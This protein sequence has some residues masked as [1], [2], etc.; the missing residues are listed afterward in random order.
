MSDL[1]S[2]VLT[3]PVQ[4]SAM[5]LIQQVAWLWE[6][7]DDMTAVRQ[8]AQV[9]VLRALAA[10]SSGSLAVVSKDEAGVF[11]VCVE[12]K[13]AILLAFRCLDS[14]VHALGFDKIPLLAVDT[15]RWTTHHIRVV[16]GS[17]IRH[18]VYLGP[19]C[20]IMPSFIN[21]GASIG[22]CTMIDSGATVGCAFIGERCH[23]SSNVTIGGVLEPMQAMPVIIEDDV[24]IGA[25]CHVVEGVRIGRGS[26]LATGVVLTSG[27][28]IIDRSTGHTLWGNIPP[29]SLVVPGAYASGR[30]GLSIQCAVIVKT[31]EPGQSPKTALNDWLR[32]SDSLP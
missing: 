7:R 16:P 8:E 4:W 31:L 2:A 1:A 3:L 28:K 23:I 5:T 9:V 12:A 29:Y 10:L 11:Q 19:S 20:I 15:Q 27:T 17:V 32:Q 26:V 25:G 30:D 6:R 14:T 21:S 18:G 22:S 13:Q 24:F